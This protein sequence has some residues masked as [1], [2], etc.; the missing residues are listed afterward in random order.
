MPK[1][2][3]DTVNFTRY[4]LK[5]CP[6]GFVTLRPLAYGEMLDRVDMAGKMAMSA[7]KKMQSAEATIEMAQGA[8][9]IFEFQHC[10]GEHNLEDADGNLLNLGNAQDIRRLDPKVGGEI[11][12]LIDKLN[13]LPADVSSGN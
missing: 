12:S 13:Q 11:A 2:V 8:V 3:A 6:E 5:S 7:D 1:A 10:I 4:D 9:Q